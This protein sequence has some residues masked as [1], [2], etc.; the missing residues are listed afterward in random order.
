MKYYELGKHSFTM[1]I[2]K[3]GEAN[4][5][6]SAKSCLVSGSGSLVSLRE[7]LEKISSQIPEN[8]L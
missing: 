5:T 7:N 2:T 6:D 8:T 1:K 4:R 3:Q